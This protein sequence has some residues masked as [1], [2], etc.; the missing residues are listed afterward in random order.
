MSLTSFSLL[1]NYTAYLCFFILQYEHIFFS[2]SENPRYA[3]SN[4]NKDM[5][6]HLILDGYQHLSKSGQETLI[7]IAGEIFKLESTFKGGIKKDE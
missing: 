2:N 7:N 6:T 4:S 5:S 3:L 1:S